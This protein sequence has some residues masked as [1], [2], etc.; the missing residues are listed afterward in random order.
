MGPSPRLDWLTH[1]G[2]GG[3]PPSF[4]QATVFAGGSVPSSLVDGFVR[5]AKA[6][7]ELPTEK[8]TAMQSQQSLSKHPSPKKVMVTV[9]R[10]SR[11]KV[12]LTATPPP[13]EGMLSP[14]HLLT[15]VW[16]LLSACCSSFVVEAVAPTYGSFMVACDH[17]ATQDDLYAIHDGAIPLFPLE[18]QVLA[19]LPTSTSYLK[20]VNI[21]SL[22]GEAIQPQKVIEFIHKSLAASSIILTAPLWVVHNSAASDTVMV[23][24]NIADMVS[25]ARAKEV[26]SRPI[27]MGG[28]IAFI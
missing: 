11:R 5:L 14:D 7:L 15:A 26:I 22:V 24:L 4:A 18:C 9:H 6:F 17:V 21:L 20:L 13:A 23:Y 28:K 16:G 25:G 19:I 2:K 8:L 1:P 10:S 27:Q 3:L 12:L